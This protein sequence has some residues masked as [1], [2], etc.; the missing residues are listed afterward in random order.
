MR[1]FFVIEEMV[2][3]EEKGTGVAIH[4]C[5]YIKLYGL[6]VYSFVCVGLYVCERERVCCHVLI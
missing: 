3:W 5:D 1:P 6:Y 4:M 2:L